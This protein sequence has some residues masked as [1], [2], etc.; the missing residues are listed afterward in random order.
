M[1]LI[2]WFYHQYSSFFFFS[3]GRTIDKLIKTMHQCIQTV[4]Y[5]RTKAVNHHTHF[6]VVFKILILFELLLV[7]KIGDADERQSLKLG[8][9]CFQRQLQSKSG[10]VWIPSEQDGVVCSGFVH[11]SI[12][13]CRWYLFYEVV[14]LLFYGVVKVKM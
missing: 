13:F 8:T 9:L 14:R 1:S 2:K 5:T 7:F 3:Y 4:W 11:F 10:R 12:D 6:I